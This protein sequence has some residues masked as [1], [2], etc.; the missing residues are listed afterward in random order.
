MKLLNSTQAYR[1]L[2]PRMQNDVEE[3]WCVSLTPC[4]QILNTKC[5]FRGTVDSC[6]VHPRDIFRF[7]YLENASGILIAHNHPSQNLEPSNE[8]ILFT[9][10]LVEASHLLK[11]SLVDHIIVTD[12]KFLSL[13]PYVKIIS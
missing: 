3:L 1:F 7:A 8:D 5:L 12:K 9:Q 13:M 6:L 2:K 10:K 11:V 4:K